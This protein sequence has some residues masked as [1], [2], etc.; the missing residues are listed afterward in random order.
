M[1]KKGFTLVELL[2]VIA[3]LAILVIIAL[4][5]VLKMYNNAKKNSFLTE[6]KTLA[7]DVSSKYITESMKG[8]KLTTI[9]NKQ[10]SLDL[11]GRNIE[12]EFKLDSN[13]KIKSMIVSDGTYCVVTTGDYT[14]LKTSD[15]S[16]KC[17]RSD[18]Y[19]PV[20]TLSKRFYSISGN[21][22]RTLVNSI[23]FY[24]DGRVIADSDSYDVSEK[25]DKSVLMYIKQ[26]S[27]NLY[28]IS[29]VAD[30][31][32]AFPENSRCL[33]QFA[34]LDSST[35]KYLGNLQKIDFN[36][37]IDTSKVTDMSAM[38]Q[39][40]QMSTLD[41]SDF[42]T[43]KV[44]TMGYMFRDCTTP[45]IKSF[46]KFNTSNVTNM[47][48]MFDGCGAVSLDLSSF[49]T[50]K[51]TR[52]DYM[53]DRSA[54]TEVKGLENFSTNNLTDMSYMFSFSKIKQLNLKNFNTSKVTN[55]AGAF[56]GVQVP[57]LDLSNF[58]TSNVTDMNNMF[59][60]SKITKILGLNKFNTLKV[61]NMSSMFG[62][63]LVETL[64]L[65]SFDTSNVTNMSYMFFKSAATTLDLSSFDTS[66]VIYM[67]AMFGNS[68]ATTGYARTQN[69]ADKFNNSSGKSSGLTFTV[70]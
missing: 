64:D 70:K 2:A 40:G 43:S 56:W 22:D 21:T 20:G 44:T 24:S 12:Y 50:S 27:N 67:D 46:N 26:N 4:P 36:N 25:Q 60:Y 45:E 6:A 5:N 61:T 58:D 16:D 52:M 41:L 38:F 66:N 37:S 1:N 9:S 7:Q 3:I 68:K 29:I 30:G 31:I 17:S 18:L 48:N 28:D 10:N 42:D 15:I 53:F 13:G 51:V 69:D 33:F 32:I 39:G 55:M 35:G 11:S 49:D 8:N 34:R 65:S 23:T 54:A 63:T 19:K 14:N 59:L 57:T 47:S 62:Y